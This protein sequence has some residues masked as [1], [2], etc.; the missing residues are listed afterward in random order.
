MVRDGPQ[1]LEWTSS[2]GCKHGSSVR[3][4]KV[5]QWCLLSSQVS[6]LK[7]EKVGKVGTKCLRLTNE[8]CLRR[9]CHWYGQFVEW[10]ADG[11][12]VLDGWK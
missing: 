12:E 4:L 5:A 8:G 10:R 6:Q 11:T 9:Q 3:S 2:N 7:L 1:I